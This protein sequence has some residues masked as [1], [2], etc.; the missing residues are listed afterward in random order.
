MGNS[1]YTSF[2]PLPNPVNDARL[3]EKALREVGFEVTLVLNADQAQ[4]KKA[5]LEFGRR[6]R[7]GVDASLFYY[8][9]HGVQVNGENYLIPTS[10]ILKMKTKLRSKPLTSTNFCGL[11]KVRNHL[12]ISWCWMRAGTIL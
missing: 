11:W 4:M 1:E 7:K 10:A 12:S 6:L 5:M 8:A 2:T 9:G 3:M